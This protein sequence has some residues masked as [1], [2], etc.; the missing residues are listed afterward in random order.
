MLSG[1]DKAIDLQDGNL[2]EYVVTGTADASFPSWAF[3]RK[4]WYLVPCTTPIQLEDGDGWS[5]ERGKVLV[6]VFKVRCFL[7]GRAQ[8]VRSSYRRP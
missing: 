3:Y 8:R 7:T 5:L 1:V 4:T 6:L 2:R